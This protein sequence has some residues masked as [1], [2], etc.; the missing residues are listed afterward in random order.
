MQITW[1]RRR[2][3]VLGKNA[4][5]GQ[6]D[7]PA[8]RRGSSRIRGRWFVCTQ[9]RSD[10]LR[11]AR[12]SRGTNGSKRR[13]RGPP[14]RD[15]RPES[16]RIRFKGIRV[17]E[18]IDTSDGT[19][20]ERAAWVLRPSNV[21]QSV[22]ALQV[23]QREDRTSLESSPR[24]KSSVPPHRPGHRHGVVRPCPHP[25]TARR[26]RSRPAEV[27]QNEALMALLETVPANHAFP[28]GYAPLVSVALS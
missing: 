16:H 2:I 12:S 9:F 25:S 8:D 28:K 24:R 11:K 5:G 22:E 23:R 7:V 4:A 6:Q 19:W 14:I 3:L 10:T 1:E 13:W 26:L 17:G 27:S 21:F 18:K 15:P 20:S